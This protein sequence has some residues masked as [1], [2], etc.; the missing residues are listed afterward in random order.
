MGVGFQIQD[1]ILNLSAGME[2]G[3]EIADD[4]LEGKR[5]LMLIRLLESCTD[6]ERSLVISFMTKGREEKRAAGVK[7][8]LALIRTLRH[9]GIRRNR[10]DDAGHR[11]HNQAQDGRLEGRQGVRGPPRGRRPF[12]GRE[13]V[14]AQETGACPDEVRAA[15]ERTRSSTPCATQAVQTVGSTVG[16]SWAGPA[17][18]TSAKEVSAAAQERPDGSTQCP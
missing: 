18:R 5:T 11:R 6:E 14:V 9:H 8:I 13:K 4:L 2:Y 10:G 15:L 7:E 16:G 3:K 1:D 12:R 17:L